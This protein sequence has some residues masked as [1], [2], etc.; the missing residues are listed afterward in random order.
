MDFDFK[1]QALIQAHSNYFLQKLTV[2][3]LVLLKQI[4]PQ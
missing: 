1:A 2:Q 3:I 4:P